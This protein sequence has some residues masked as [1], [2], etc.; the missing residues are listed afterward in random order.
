MNIA[1][2][3]PLTG[4]LAFIIILLTMPL[5]HALMIITE[6]VFGEVYV[7]TAAFILGSI[8]VAL[9]IIGM[10]SEN[11]TGATFLGLFAGILI[12]TGWIEF[13]FV[14]FANHVGV[15]PLIENGEVV[16]K[17]E[18]LILPSSIGFMA[19]MFIYFLFN[20]HTQCNFFRWLQRNLKIN[21]VNRKPPEKDR[22]FALI[23]ATEIITIMWTFYIV[24]MLIYDNK[25]FGDYHPVTYVFA[26][27]S[28]LWSFYLFINLL[29]ITK[30]GYAIRYGIPVVIIFWNVVEILGRWDI[31]DEIWVKP[32]EYKLE[33]LSILI[34]LLFLGA[35]LIYENRNK[36][37]NKL[38]NDKN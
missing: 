30:M 38:N 20:R 14:F 15:Q 1:I 26:F 5:G 13:S 35:I 33:I 21:F 36:K 34:V 31:Y 28:L 16:T 6:H 22:S 29:K 19:F 24:L 9:L 37:H 12:W 7:Y 25:I 3:K 8:G 27:G 4:I 32:L 23:T 2:K 10:K 11:E 17:P 18:Y